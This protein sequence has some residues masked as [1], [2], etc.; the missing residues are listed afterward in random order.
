MIQ[1]VRL[2]L[3]VKSASQSAVF[4]SHKKTASNTFNQSDQPKRTGPI[5]CCK[6]LD[7]FCKAS[8][9]YM[10]SIPGLAIS[11]LI[12]TGPEPFLAK[13]DRER[14]NRTDPNKESIAQYLVCEALY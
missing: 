4:F 2:R 7:G 5:A 14:H 6:F 8:L 10:E 1:P 13:K 11:S 12:S 3:S 9:G